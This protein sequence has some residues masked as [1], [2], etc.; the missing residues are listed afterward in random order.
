[1]LG[2][3][4]KYQAEIIGIRKE[5]TEESIWSNTEGRWG[6]ETQNKRGT[7]KRNQI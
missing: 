2:L 6:V 5:G 7:G 1:M 4:G 3:N